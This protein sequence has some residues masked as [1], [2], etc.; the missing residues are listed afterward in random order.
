MILKYP[1]G[2]VW[3]TVRD[4]ERKEEKYLKV[5]LEYGYDLLGRRTGKRLYRWHD[6]GEAEPAPERGRFFWDGM[7]LCGE[8]SPGKVIEVQR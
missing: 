2:T 1:T 3:E 6:E 4:D 8:D 7:R 5:E